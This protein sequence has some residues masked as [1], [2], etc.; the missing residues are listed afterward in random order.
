[1][2]KFPKVILDFPTV[3]KWWSVGK[4]FSAANHK[5]FKIKTAT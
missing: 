3:V 5:F 2:R 4:I 1:M